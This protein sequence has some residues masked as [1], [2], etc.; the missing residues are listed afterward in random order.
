MLAAI[1]DLYS[2]TQMR[3]KVNGKTSVGYVI[4][5]SGIK[6]GC[7]VSPLLFGLFIEQ[8]HHMLRTQC[9]H[10]G[11]TIMGGDSLRDML[12]ADDV[13]LL[14]YSHD[15]LEELLALL[16]VF[17]NNYRM[18]VNVGKTKWVAFYPPPCSSARLTATSD[19]C[20]PD[21]RSVI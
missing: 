5:V 20:R 13:A 14:S 7:P 11:V 6:Q 2:N 18:S 15:E 16:H 12:Y 21:V 1:K 17:C 4:T 9:P 19:L 3:V 8:L 10:I